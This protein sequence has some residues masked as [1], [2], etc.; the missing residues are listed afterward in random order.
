MIG[1]V[2]PLYLGEDASTVPAVKQFLQYTKKV[3][4]SWVPDL[5]TLFGWASAQLFVQALQ[6]AGPN[7][8]RGAVIDQLKKITSFD[9][10]GMVSPTN[11][12][13]KKPSACFMIGHHQERQV[14]ARPAQVGFRLQHQ[15]LLRFVR[16]RVVGF[17]RGD[18]GG[19]RR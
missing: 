14:R 18:A 10:S 5:Y 4:S 2:F 13:Q 8:T 11:P 15:V 3:N 16:G 17:R 1:Q 6:A 7:P 19:D 9:A 12:A